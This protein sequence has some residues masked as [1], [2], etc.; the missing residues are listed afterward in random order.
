MVILPSMNVNMF[1]KNEHVTCR[2]RPYNVCGGEYLR[3]STRTRVHSR[4]EINRT[5]NCGGRG[6][7]R[8][9]AAIRE[10]IRS[11]DEDTTRP[12][13]GGALKCATIRQNARTN[14]HDTPIGRSVS[15]RWCTY[16]HR[17][18]RDFPRARARYCIFCVVS[19]R[20]QELV[21][22]NLLIAS[23]AASKTGA[24]TRLG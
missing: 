12:G 15:E 24:G 7:V 4:R 19:F 10:I 5:W 2:K 23:A 13:L 6:N 1:E 8:E 3:V 21:S 22:R 20:A 17:F 14:R 18:A 9:N 16:I 11:F